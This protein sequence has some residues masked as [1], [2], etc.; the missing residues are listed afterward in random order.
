MTYREMKDARDAEVAARKAKD[1]ARMAR[2]YG[3][4]FCAGMQRFEMVSKRKGTGA[5]GLGG[6]F[7]GGYGVW[8]DF[9]PKS[10]ADRKMYARAAVRTVKV[11]RESAELRLR[12]AKRARKNSRRRIAQIRAALEA[13]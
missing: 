5:T 1:A 13:L 6:G 12:W 10:R 9:T 3:P 7:G 4:S 11:Q 2:I 8:P